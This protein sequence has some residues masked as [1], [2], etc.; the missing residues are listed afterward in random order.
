[1]RD[2]RSERIEGNYASDIAPLAGEL[3]LLIDAN[4]DI[5]QRARTQVGNL[6]HALKTPLSVLVNEASTSGGPLADKVVEQSAVMRHHV[7]YYLK[8]ARAAAIAATLGAATEV[9]PVVDGLARV[10]VKV[11][12][13]RGLD[14]EADVPADLKFRGEK[15]DLE[16]MIGN[17]VDNACKWAAERVSIEAASLPGA[18]GL[19]FALTVDNDGPALSE[20][21]RKSVL[22]RGVRLDETKP[23][24]GLGLSI[25]AD[26]AG[27]YGGRVELL[28]SPLG[29]VRARLELPAV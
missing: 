6:A 13:D 15:Q 18:G 3:N 4:R 25:V 16:E 19:R 5:L 27:M 22:K 2:G 17:L 21:E 9:K 29:G 14:V 12:L 1:V 7:D 23:G 10:F 8:R 26:L 24:S 11:N 28:D 20:D